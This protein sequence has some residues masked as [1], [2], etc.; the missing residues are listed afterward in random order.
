MLLPQSCGGCTSGNY[1]RRWTVVKSDA[2]V[3]LLTVLADVLADVIGGDQRDRG[4][5]GPSCHGAS[6]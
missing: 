5:V 3:F 2:A 1:L 4:A 6:W